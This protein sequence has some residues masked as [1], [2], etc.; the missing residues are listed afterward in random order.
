MLGG[1]ENAVKDGGESR[2]GG[3]KVRTRTSS[4]PPPLRRTQTCVR[5]MMPLRPAGGAVGDLGKESRRK[6]EITTRGVLLRHQENIKK[7]AFF[8][9]RAGGRTR[10]RRTRQQKERKRLKDAKELNFLA[11]HTQS[12]DRKKMNAG[13]G[14]YRSRKRHQRRTAQ[15]RERKQKKKKKKKKKVRHCNSRAS[16]LK[17]GT[18]YA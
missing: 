7:R 5:E 1:V 9:N 12:I 3:G 4:T 16:S 18:Q 14:S 11:T 15:G 2:G 6:R 8:R 10:L 17:E 13:T